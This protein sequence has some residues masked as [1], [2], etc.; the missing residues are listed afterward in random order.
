MIVTS[1]QVSDAKARSCVTRR[2][3]VTESGFLLDLIVY[4]LLAT[5]RQHR[6]IASVMSDEIRAKL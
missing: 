4:L 3:G 2:R 6:K 1:S 5:V